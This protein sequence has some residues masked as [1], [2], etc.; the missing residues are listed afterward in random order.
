[1]IPFEQ[2][3]PEA[4][5]DPHLLETLKGEGP[6]VLNWMLSGLRAY[7]KD[8]L[9]IP[10]EIKAATAAYREEQDILGDW[11]GE[12][13]KTGAGCSV[14]KSDL[15]AGYVGWAKQNGHKPSSQSKLTRRLKERGYTV[16]A[17]KRTVN[18]L[19][20]AAGLGWGSNP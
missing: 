15:Y 11:I 3:I 4:K 17:D 5:R 7:Q 1:M 8:G 12:S 6:G 2:T 19:A 16:A 14:K 18:G 13:C 20:L 9:Q 10:E